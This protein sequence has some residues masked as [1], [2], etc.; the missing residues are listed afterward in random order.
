MQMGG[1]DDIGGQPHLQ[2]LLSNSR[3]RDDDRGWDS[4]LG[5]SERGQFIYEP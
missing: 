1:T 5:T 3:E 4:R 2:H